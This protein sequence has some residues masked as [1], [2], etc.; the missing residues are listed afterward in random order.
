MTICRHCSR[1]KVNRPRGLCW[2]CWH[3]VEVRERYP[4]VASRY[5]A[6]GHGNGPGGYALP[7][8]TAA[9]PG[10]PEKIAVLERRARDGLA[11]FHPLDAGGAAEP[12]FS[13]E[14]SRARLREEGGRVV[15]LATPD[16]GLAVRDEWIYCTRGGGRV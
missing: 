7:E 2:T 8:P 14:R 16:G 10:T 4:I 3:D 6:R 12:V 9:V 13:R 11:L 15:R 5:T 1:G